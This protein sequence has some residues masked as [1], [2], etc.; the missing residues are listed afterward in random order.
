MS[1]SLSTEDIPETKTE[2][3][4]SWSLH[5]RQNYMN[6]YIICPEVTRTWEKKKTSQLK[7]NKEYQSI[8]WGRT[9]MGRYFSLVLSILGHMF[10]SLLPRAAREKSWST[11]ES[12][13]NSVYLGQIENKV[14]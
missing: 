5:F 6:K 3:L 9:G 4:L 12:K 11:Q 8:G 2:S 13:G 14:T 1:D 10:C 7:R